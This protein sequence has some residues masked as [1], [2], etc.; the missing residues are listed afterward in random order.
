MTM[1][2]A[3]QAIKSSTCC[4]CGKQAHGLVYRKHGEEVI[5]FCENHLRGYEQHKKL[6]A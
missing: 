1:N 5:Y 2:K 3:A 4:K 6:V